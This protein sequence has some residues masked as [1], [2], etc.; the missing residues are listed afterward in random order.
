[1]NDD[2]DHLASNVLGMDL[3]EM[4][5]SHLER[6]ALPGARHRT[7]A[8]IKVQDGC[9]AHCT[10]CVTRVAR[11]PSRGMPVDRVLTNIRS[12]LE[13]GAR[14]IIL[15]GVQLGTWGKHFPDPS[16]VKVLVQRVLNETDVKRLR[17]SSIEPWDLDRDFFRLFEDRRLC[18]HLHISLQSGCASTLKRMGRQSTPE[19][20]MERLRWAREID[21]DFSITT[22][23]ITGFPGETREEFE[24][25]LH[26]IRQAGFSGGHV[27][28]YSDRP[29]TPAVKL[30][31]QVQSKERKVRAAEAR[32]VLAASADQFARR[33]IGKQGQVLWETST[34]E[35]N[36]FRLDGFCETYVRVSAWSGQDKYNVVDT[37]SFTGT[38]ENCLTGEILLQK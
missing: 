1:V 33:L 8:F 23:V 2:K 5:L 7:R 19:E 25:S 12:A 9:D 38:G 3:S 22:D 16:N 37:V 18:R 27:F 36:G 13:G 14:E 10:F 20:Y 4:D 28:P 29:G 11:G 17:F 21:P 6:E 24:Q 34:P 15:S 35:R 32:S 31:G 26:F 30:P